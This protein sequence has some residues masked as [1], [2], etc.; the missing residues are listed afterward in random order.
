MELALGG[1]PV[2]LDAAKPRTLLALLLLDVN[3]VAERDW[4]IDQLW[5]GRPPE[6]AKA[7]LR[8]YVYQIRKQLSRFDCGVVL[9]GRAGGYALEVAD[10]SVDMYRFEALSA[11]GRQAL[12]HRQF[13][14]AVNAFKGGLGL[15]RG[16][17]A[18]SGIDVPSVREKARLLDELRIE[19]TEQ[20]LSA[21]L[22]SGAPTAAA[23][24]LEA[25]TTVHPLREGLW[26][27]LML[28]LYRAGRQGEALEV[29]QRL[30]RLLDDELGIKPSAL[31]EQLHQQILAGD[32][33]LQHPA[34][35]PRLEASPD[36]VVPK[37]LPASAAHFTGRESQ[38]AELNELLSNG[39]DS[40][41]RPGEVVV[42][43]IIGMAGIGKTA[44]AV[45]WAHHIADRFPDGQLYV[46][47][48]GCGPVA[49]PMEPAEAIRIFLD[50]LGVPPERIPTDL[51][52]Q[53]GLYRSLL[54]DKRVLVVLDNAR[55]ANQVRPLLPGMSG[56]LVVITSRN[57]LSSLI[58]HGACPISLAPLDAD[59]ARRFLTRR[60]RAQR[61]TA[62]PEAIGQTIDACA[63]LP[64]ALAI[65]A[66]RA[67]VHPDCRLGA[68]TAKLSDAN[69]RLDAHVDPDPPLISPWRPCGRTLP[70]RP[71]PLG[72]SGSSA[73]TPAPRS[74]P[75]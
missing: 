1:R 7:T 45:H 35:V 74:G 18:F 24:E 31:V 65:I 60:L 49:Q 52:A 11:Q 40:V 67:A 2:A 14:D 37:Q 64:L 41:D 32:P 23:A 73:C 71:T 43:A 30:Y 69:Y 8:A 36:R 47:L 28:S 46:D 56:S 38:L 12:Q 51:D 17:A 6:G 63:G 75:A 58:A 62:E 72:C 61:T 54:A 9:R 34:A 48:R 26:R 55:D 4:L 15:W 25:L 22:E 44:L 33:Q 68:L 5:A 53:A 10:A 50:A 3:Q 16:A 59:D 66:A 70:A 20:C 13:G 39:N 57:R 21:E 29:Y 27:L 19:V 42:A